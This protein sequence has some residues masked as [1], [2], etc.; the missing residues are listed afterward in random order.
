MRCV[1]EERTYALPYIRIRVTGY[2]TKQDMQT[3]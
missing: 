2:E 3:K 1:F